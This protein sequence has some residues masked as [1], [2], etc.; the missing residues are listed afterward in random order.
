[1]YIFKN[2]LKLMFYVG[3]V[4]LLTGGCSGDDVETTQHV[5][6]QLQT[7]EQIP[8][9]KW[10]KLALKKIFFGHQSVGNNIM[11]GISEIQ[12][13]DPHIQLN[14][15][16]T[17][18]V[19]FFE[20]PVFAHDSN[21]GKNHHPLLKVEAFVKLMD[22]GLGDKTD[23]AFLKFCFVDFQTGTDIKNIFKTYCDSIEKLKL[24]FPNLT[25]VHFTV[26]LLR[27]EKT[28]AVNMMK[29]FVN[30]L[31]GKK[32]DSFFSNSHNVVRNEYNKLLLS[33]YSGKEPIFDLARLESTGPDGKRET[34]TFNG[35][36]YFALVPVY[37]DD[38]GH[39]NKKGRKYIAEQLLI[40]L[41]EL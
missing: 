14:I 40:F 15:V 36:N 4:F 32:K 20:K 26:P 41:A 7:I 23:I 9:R 30:G 39:L 11:K 27:Q 17:T 13:D 35:Q 16:E 31:M 22:G 18:D 29:N 2:I 38:G 8:Q 34:F 24:R 33:H 37:T 5:D 21:L 1:V 25:I 19:T 28:G 3:V 10:D 12:S 6:K